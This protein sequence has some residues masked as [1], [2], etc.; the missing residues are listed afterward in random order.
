M[1][2]SVSSYSKISKIL[3][4]LTAILVVIAFYDGLGGNESRVYLPARDATRQLH[5][6]LGIAVLALLVLRVIWRAF[7]ERP[8][9]PESSR[10]MALAAKSVQFTLYVL[11][12][13]V[14]LTAVLGAWFE[15]HAVT[16]LSGVVL[17]SPF[18]SSHDL[19]VNLSNVH[20]FLANAILWVAG[21]HALAA[22][23]HHYVL[24]DDVLKS[25]LPDWFK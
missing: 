23:Y 25:M 11:L 24:K 10:M 1:T 2:P 14:P 9:K 20:V 16:L 5:E 17:N 15:G 6:T 12:L 8:V 18:Q 3:H 7:D 21:L 22:L 4:W 19:G 13:A